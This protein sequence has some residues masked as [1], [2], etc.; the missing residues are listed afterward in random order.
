MKKNMLIGLLLGT[1]A[2]VIDVVPMLLQ[3]LTWDAN[4][5]AFS[6]WVVSGFLLATSG[7]KG[8]PILKGI[9]I[10]FLCLIPSAVLIGWKNPLALLPIAAM[11]LVLGALLGLVYGKL[12]KSQGKG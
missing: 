2:G 4:L 1:A 12:I 3:K 8:S 5:S 11:T 10:P 6:L 7:L 9:L